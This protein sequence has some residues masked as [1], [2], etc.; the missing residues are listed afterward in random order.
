[1][2]QE[3]AAKRFVVDS[4]LGKLAKWL[5]IL[6][7]DTRYEALQSEDQLEAHRSQG[8]LLITRRQKLLNEAN[9]LFLKA[10]APSNNSG[11]SSPECPSLR[12]KSTCCSAVPFATSNS[13][14][15]PGMRCLTRFPITSFG[16]K[17]SFTA[18]PG[19]GR[20]T[21]PAAIPDECGGVSNGPWVGRSLN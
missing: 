6:G 12:R 2:A 21:G 1:M 18:V 17:R 8:Y 5:R 20:S 13:C 3:G 14:R 9:V 16:P 19:A 10:N 15:Q 4:M 7:F 11:R